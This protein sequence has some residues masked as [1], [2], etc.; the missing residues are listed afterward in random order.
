MPWNLQLGSAPVV[1]DNR[2]GSL[3]N[4]GETIAW[5]NVSRSLTVAV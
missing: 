3:N 1:A 5:V 2:V 4:G